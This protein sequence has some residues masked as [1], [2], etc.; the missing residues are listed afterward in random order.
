VI[1][2]TVGTTLPF[3]ELV[4]V[5][6]RLVERAQLAEPVVCQIGHGTYLPKHCDHFRFTPNIEEWLDKASVVVGHGGTGTVS[7]LLARGRPFVAVS[8]PNA[9]DDHQAQ[10]LTRLSQHVSLLWT[11][12]LNELPALIER[13]PSFQI[14]SVKGQHLAADLKA[15]L[16]ER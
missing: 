7:S 11:K 5:V 14:Q 15:F 13:A 3:D 6:D 10:F 4:Q 1:F 8:N 9:A 16:A 2:V 12:D